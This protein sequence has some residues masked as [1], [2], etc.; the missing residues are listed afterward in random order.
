MADNESKQIIVLEAD[1]ASA[2]ATQ[3]LLSNVSSDVK[4]L[5]KPNQLKGL[6]QSFDSFDATLTDTS[7]RFKRLTENIKETKDAAQD[8]SKTKIDAF[9]SIPEEDFAAPDSGGGSK[10]NKLQEVGA[11]IRNLPSVQIPGL[12]IGTDAVGNLLRVSGAIKEA[13]DKAKAAAAVTAA[14]A[15]V[16]T[17]AETGQAAAAGTVA[18]TSTSAAAGMVALA[19][20][21]APIAAIGAVVAA[22][23]ILIKGAMDGFSASAAENSAKVK[24]AYEATDTVFDSILNGDTSEDARKKIEIEQKKLKQ[25]NDE[26]AAAWQQ[27]QER[28]AEIAAKYGTVAAEIA[29]NRGTDE[30]A[31]FAERQKEQQEVAKKAQAAIDEYTRAI[32][33]NEFAANDAAKAEEERRKEEEK[34]AAEAEKLAK[35]IEAAEER[36]V[37]ARRK[38]AEKIQDNARQSAQKLED[39]ER[40]A[41][42]KRADAALKYNDDLVNIA[43]KARRDEADAQLK[44]QQKETDAATKNRQAEADALLK[45]QRTM[46]DIRRDALRNEED[47]LRDRNFLGATLASESA[48]DAIEDANKAALREAEDRATQRNIEAQ[49]RALEY[50]REAQERSMNLQR[51][52]TDRMTAYQIEQRDAVT[53]Y[54]RQIRDADTATKRQEE[55]TRIAYDRELEQLQNHL[56][57]KLALEGEEQAAERAL[58]TG[59]VKEQALR[60][61]N[62]SNSSSQTNINDNRQWTFTPGSF[63]GGM[64]IQQMIQREVITTMQAIRYKR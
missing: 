12:G 32:K 3:R 50:Q 2:A 8:L 13:S 59:A 10:R 39:I 44:I 19:A 49:E 48:K 9:D 51:A 21:A 25:A 4:A 7:K 34:K 41:A 53:A 14:A 6:D 54:Q 28:Y 61:G 38:N 37:D 45:Q 1:K 47:Q 26:A 46:D 58:K 57:A 40:S 27:S 29:K 15:A 16:A 17:T 11:N 5:G 33:D 60:V 63:G 35:E 30:F 31:D 43:L 22:G 56:N 18:V 64:P 62:T 36:I 52:R 42:D 23:F 55:S 20:A 24:R